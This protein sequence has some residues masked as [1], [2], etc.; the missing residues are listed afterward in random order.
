MRR[1]CEEAYGMENKFRVSCAS[2]AIYDYNT[3][4]KQRWRRHGEIGSW[5]SELGDNIHGA[6]VYGVVN[7]FCCW[8]SAEVKYSNTITVKAVYCKYCICQHDDDDYMTG[9]NNESQLSIVRNIIKNIYSFSFFLKV[10]SWL[11]RGLSSDDTF[12]AWLEC[13]IERV[14]GERTG[15]VKQR[16]TLWGNGPCRK[17]SFVFGCQ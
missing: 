13:V 12:G 3:R 4:N 10:P 6:R 5:S 17:K 11:C 14:C 1:I 7:N 2:K 15:S 9:E 16:V 8:L